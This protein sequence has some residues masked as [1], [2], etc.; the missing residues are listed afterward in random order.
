MPDS[1][2]KNT[3]KGAPSAG[4]YIKIKRTGN[5]FTLIE[6][7]K[8]ICFGINA[9]KYE[10]NLAVFEYP[11]KVGGTEKNIAKHKDYTA[12]LKE[13]LQSQGMVFVLSDNIE[14][15]HEINADGVIVKSAS[16]AKRA[17]EILGDNAIIGLRLG[18][19]RKK[20]ND[21]LGLNI[22]YISLPLNQKTKNLSLELIKLWASRTDKLCLVEGQISNN[23]CKMLVSAGATFIDS[24]H[25]VFHHPSGILQGVVNMLYAIE[26]ATPNNT[27]H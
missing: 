7:I 15:A 6:N 2:Q 14:L 3:Q 1:T 22:E 4:L 17:R 11:G 12:I 21:A 27:I 5:K 10:K 20:I 24:S 19:S 9:S 18:A 26:I 13:I 23:D 16:E 25:Y 8:K